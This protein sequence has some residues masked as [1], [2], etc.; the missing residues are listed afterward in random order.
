MLRNKTNGTSSMYL[1]SFR[2]NRKLAAVMMDIILPSI[3]DCFILFNIKYMPGNFSNKFTKTRP[4]GLT[5]F[6][7]FSIADSS[8]NFRKL[9]YIYI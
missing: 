1:F 2:K 5:P 9:L 6:S 4:K 3:N 7:F 8:L